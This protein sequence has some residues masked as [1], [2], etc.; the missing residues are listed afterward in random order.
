MLQSVKNIY[1]FFMAVLATGFYRYPA[2]KLTVIGVTGTDGKTT[3]SHMIYQI[4]QQAGKNVGIV[5]TLGAKIG[6]KHVD[7]GLH[8]TTPSPFALQKLLNEM[9]KQGCEYAIIEA[10][11]HG[12]DQNRL[13]GCNFSYGVLTNITHEHWDYHKNFENYVKA[14]AKLFRGVKASV[15]NTDGPWFE[16]LKKYT[17]GG[18]LVT[19]GLTPSADY[20]PSTFPFQLTIT[21]DYNRQNALGAV[22][23]AKTLGIANQPIRN[24]LARFKNLEGR[25]EEIN[26]GQ[27]FRVIVDFAHTPYATEQVLKTLKAETNGRLI[28]MFGSAGLRDKTKRPIT[29]KVAATY[30]HICIVTADDPATEDVNDIIS[31]IIPGCIEAGAHEIIGLNPVSGF[32][33]EVGKHVFCRIP[34]RKEAIQAAI[35]IARPGD[36]VALLSKGHQKSFSLGKEEIPWNEA[37][38]A[39]EAVKRRL[40]H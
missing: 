24:A 7:V 36:T 13:V 26:E 35:G 31:Q 27:P 15:I 38:L 37:A 5:G 32:N 22:A 14:K 2:K 1:H 4:L 33:P 16:A 17:L 25:F 11:S 6:D 21:G 3:T 39:R 19:F 10:T 34:D 30:A 12:L 23:I 8:V 28:A 18:K 29:G 40:S 9:V 20:N